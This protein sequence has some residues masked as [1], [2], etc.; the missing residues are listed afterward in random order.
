MQ[1]GGEGVA[2]GGRVLRAG[3]GGPLPQPLGRHPAADATRALVNGDVEAGV[4]EDPG[5]AD[6]RYPGADH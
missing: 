2:G 4:G 1:L 6:S 3:V 5:A